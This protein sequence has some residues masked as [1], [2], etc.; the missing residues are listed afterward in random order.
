MLTREL[1]G[2]ITCAIH[3][4]L[5]TSSRDSP[6]LIKKSCSMNAARITKTNWS[7]KLMQKTKDAEKRPASM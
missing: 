7:M 3:D 2:I 5:T 6:S 4:V 1:F